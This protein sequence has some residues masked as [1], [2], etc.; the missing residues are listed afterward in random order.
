MN[1]S[2]MNG[3]ISFWFSSQ[4]LA[5]GMVPA[6][7][8]SSLCGLKPCWWSKFFSS[9][10]YFLQIHLH[11]KNFLLWILKS[12]WK[13]SVFSESGLLRRWS[14]EGGNAGTR[15]EKVLETSALGATPPS[16]MYYCIYWEHLSS[17][18]SKFQLY[19]T[20]VNYSQYIFIIDH[21]TFSIL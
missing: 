3:E 5:S 9:I 12:V 2:P 1:I 15:S 17:T 20:L 11:C 21:Q 19:D 16:P 18:I 4:S 8:Q 7:P 13:L 6:W 10:H 14:K